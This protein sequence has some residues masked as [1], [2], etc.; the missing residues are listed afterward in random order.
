MHK[1]VKTI[2]QAVQFLNWNYSKG[3]VRAIRVFADG[4][5]EADIQPFGL[6]QITRRGHI[7]NNKTIRMFQHQITLTI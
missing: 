2:R 4:K 3:D 1:Q 5:I 6:R 7:F